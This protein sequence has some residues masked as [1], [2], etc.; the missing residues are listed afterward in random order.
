MLL[1]DTVVIPNTSALLP[2]E[3]YLSLIEQ[4][5]ET[6]AIVLAAESLASR[7]GQEPDAVTTVA[8]TQVRWGDRVKTWLEV[9]ARFRRIAAS[10]VAAALPP[11]WGGVASAV[12]PGETLGPRNGEYTRGEDTLWPSRLY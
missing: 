1:G 5:G 9:A 12:R 2:D 7:Y 6:M 3:T 4:N 8:G 11:A 10:E